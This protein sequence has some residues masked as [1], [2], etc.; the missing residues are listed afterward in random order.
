VPNTRT[1]KQIHDD[2]LTQ[3]TELGNNTQQWPSNKDDA[4][5][6]FAHHVLMA[7]YGVQAGHG[8]A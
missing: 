8:Q 7:I 1:G 6:L 4:Y 5:R 3:L 2:L